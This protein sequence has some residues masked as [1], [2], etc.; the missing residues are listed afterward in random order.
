MTV[1]VADA[2]RWV[3][4]GLVLAAG[5][6]ESAAAVR[7]GRPAVRAE[8][9]QRAVA[10]DRRHRLDGR[11]A[12]PDHQQGRSTP[13]DARRLR[14]RQREGAVRLQA[15]PHDWLRRGR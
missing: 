15:V 6:V 10:T 4:A 14:P 8:V 13:V 11:A 12:L 1:C 9:R 5:L 7:G 2:R 3:A